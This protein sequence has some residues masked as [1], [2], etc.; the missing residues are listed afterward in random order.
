MDCIWIGNLFIFIHCCIIFKKQWKYVLL[1]SLSSDKVDFH[2]GWTH[3]SLTP[4]LSIETLHC[5]VGSQ[6]IVD[7]CRSANVQYVLIS[8]LFRLGWRIWLQGP[9]TLIPGLS[10][11]HG[12]IKEALLPMVWDD[13]SE[14][15][16][17]HQSMCPKTLE[18]PSHKCLSEWVTVITLIKNYWCTVKSKLS[19]LNVKKLLYISYSQLVVAYACVVN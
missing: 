17:S 18:D 3:N 12:N 10:S 8:C 4:L 1:C 6:V 16:S 15:G 7:Y 19:F 5:V 2:D 9:G 11:F 13:R 14:T